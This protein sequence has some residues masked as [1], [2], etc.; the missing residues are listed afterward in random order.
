M[1]KLGNKRQ[2]NK[3]TKLQFKDVP[4]YELYMQARN[5]SVTFE[6]L[7]QLLNEYQQSEIE[8][9]DALEEISCTPSIHD[10]DKQRD[11]AKMIHTFGA[12]ISHVKQVE[13]LCELDMPT[14]IYHGLEGMRKRNVHQNDI[15]LVRMHYRRACG[16]LETYKQECKQI[17]EIVVGMIKRRY[18]DDSDADR[19]KCYIATYYDLFVTDLDLITE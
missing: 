16:N 7:E 19:C 15:N 14:H 1:Q 10:E 3:M 12:S 6:E 2:V 13:L 11:I 5:Q 17:L 9:L 8:R 4:L 18:E